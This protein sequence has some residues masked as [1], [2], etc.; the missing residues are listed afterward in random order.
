MCEPDRGQGNKGDQE[1]QS[2]MEDND[3]GGVSFFFHQIVDFEPAY[4]APIPALAQ[5][6]IVN[7]VILY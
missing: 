7:S 3:D 2:T 4:F 6:K 1:S 5:C